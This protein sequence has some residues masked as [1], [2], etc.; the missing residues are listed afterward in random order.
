M[1]D[2]TVSGGGW[3]SG[4]FPCHRSPAK[5]GTRAT[6]SVGTFQGT[7]ASDSKP[8]VPSRIQS[9]AKTVLV[10]LDA[11]QEIHACVFGLPRLVVFGRASVL[12]RPVPDLEVL[13]EERIVHDLRIPVALT[14]GDGGD[15]RT[16]HHLQDAE[17]P[18]SLRPALRDVHQLVQRGEGVLEGG[19]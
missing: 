12:L 16:L 6:D 13:P 17:G 7:S 19:M 10:L 3:P 4:R 18:E 9:R 15:L 11:S 5:S 14:L 2:R 8:P 1:S